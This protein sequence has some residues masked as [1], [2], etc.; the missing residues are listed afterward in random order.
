MQTESFPING[1]TSR[2]QL[3]KSPGDLRIAVPLFVTALLTEI[4]GIYWRVLSYP[5]IQDDWGLLRALV[6]Q[7]ALSYLSGAVSPE[8]T[9]FYRPLSLLYFLLYHRLFGLNALPFHVIGLAI[10]LLNSLLVSFISWKLTGNRLISAAT[11]LVYAAAITVH[12]DP[13]LWLV[14]FYD[15][16]AS[17]FYFAS[18]ALFLAGR[19][20]L[21]AAAFGAALLAKESTLVLAVVLVV[22]LVYVVRP[23]KNVAGIVCRALWPHGLILAGYILAR[24]GNMVSLFS[25]S[26]TDPYRMKLFGL[27]LFKNLF[28]YS[29]WSLEAIS[30]WR[31]MSSG[32]ASWILWTTVIVVGAV[33]VL[34]RKSRHPSLF[35]FGWIAFL[36]GWAVAGISPALLLPNHYYK[37]YLAYSMPALVLMAC[38]GLHWVSTLIARP[39]S[40]PDSRVIPPG[41]PWVLPFP[42]SMP[43]TQSPLMVSVF[44]VFVLANGLSAYSYFRMKDRAGISDR[45]TVGTNH[46]IYRGHIANLILDYLVREHPTVPRG[47]V[48]ILDGCD[49]ESLGGED[50]LRTFYRDEA[51][52]VFSRSEVVHSGTVFYL[53]IRNGKVEEQGKW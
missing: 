32:A 11:G 14:G 43:G 35:P 52:R 46:L 24:I 36:L 10:L 21:S 6:S 9:L 26:G 33:L 39:S 22:M 47:S 50:G 3:L 2:S 49:P 16:S 12:L 42:G 17:L 37:Y 5:F 41:S 25:L 44:V 48:F 8:G 23:L 34:S 51:I 30:P 53:R 18:I 27:H 38:S 7:D 28:R 31:G 19:K 15:L 1:R 29:W 20:F 4:G 40:R 45:Y 13:L